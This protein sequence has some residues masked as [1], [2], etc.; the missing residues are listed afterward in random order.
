MSTV[1][2]DEDLLRDLVATFNLTYPNCSESFA[3]PLPRL[4]RRK[5]R[6]LVHQLE[7]MMAT[8]GATKAA[9]ILR[10]MGTAARNNNLELLPQFLE[11]VSGE[12]ARA[13]DQ[14]GFHLGASA[15]ALPKTV[16][17]P[18]RTMVQ[19]RGRSASK[20]RF[21]SS[22]FTRGSPRKPHCRP[23]VCFATRART[24]ASLILRSRAMRGT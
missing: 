2:H 5:F 15:D 24:S 1:E 14:P 3:N 11:D 20:S 22:T 23:R 12:L 18:G 6:A 9:V 4:R 17:L 13:K 7:G 19:R 21:S 16:R 8:L 10:Q